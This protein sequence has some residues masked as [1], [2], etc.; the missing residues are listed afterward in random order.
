VL[1]AFLVEMA[2][3]QGTPGGIIPRIA[4][5]V[6][7]IAY[8]GLLPA[9]FLQL[10][11]LPAGDFREPGRAAWALLMLLAVTKCGDIGAY[12]TGKFFAGRIFPAH[13]MTPSLSPKKTWEGAC[14]GLGTSVGVTFLISYVS[15]IGHGSV[16]FCLGFGISVGIAGM[17]GDLAESLIKRD[18]ETKDASNTM[19]GFG[20]VL[21]VI[22]SILFAAPVAY[23]WL[24]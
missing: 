24:S 11:F 12:F 23:L 13:K 7:V 1:G 19:P 18:Y 16:L 4:L 20:G 6:L 3:F 22:D 9:F 21:D 5:N 15:G 14:G 2:A 8:L 17:L 10:R